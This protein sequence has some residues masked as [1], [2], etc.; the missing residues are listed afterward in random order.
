LRGCNPVGIHYDTNA[1]TSSPFA[2][3]K[4]GATTEGI[5]ERIV[6]HR[7][8]H[9]DAGCTVALLQRICFLFRPFAMIS[10]TALFTNVGDIGSR[11]RRGRPSTR[12]RGHNGPAIA[13]FARGGPAARRRGVLGARCQPCRVSMYAIRLRRTEPL[14]RLAQRQ[15]AASLRRQTDYRHTKAAPE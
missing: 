4:P 9:V 15:S 10:M 3:G 11:L 13:G 2:G 7:G 5:S 6:Q 8:S 1:T 12:G 14:A